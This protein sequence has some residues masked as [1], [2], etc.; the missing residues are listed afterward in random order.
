M[1]IPVTQ[2]FYEDDVKP[3]AAQQCI[4]WIPVIPDTQGLAMSYL[5]G[6][7]GLK[8][9]TTNGTKS[10]RGA[11]VMDGIPY[12]V[13]GNNLYRVNA[14]GASDDLGAIAGT[15][16][17]SFADNGK[18]LCV[19]VPNSTG[20]IYKSEDETLTE[21]TDSNY[22]ALGPSLQVVYKDGYF[23]HLAKDLYFISAL[24]DGLTY[25]ALD[26]GT[27]E[28]NPDSNTAIH[29]NRN[30]GY[31]AGSETIQQFQ[32]VG[33]ADF[34]FSIT[35]GAVIQKGVKAKFSVVDFD[36]SFV[37]LGGGANEQPAIWLFTGS[38]VVK[39]STKAIDSV[40]KKETEQ[41]LKDVY[42][43]THALDGGFFVCF[44]FSDTS[45]C[46]DADASAKTGRTIWH[47][48][49]SRTAAQTQTKWR[50][51]SIVQAYGKLLVGDILGPTIG[52]I[53]S[54]AFSEYGTLIDRDVATGPLHN[55]GKQ[56][57]VDELEVTVESGQG[58]ADSPEPMITMSYSTDGGNTFSNELA[59]SMGKV[60]ERNKRQIWRRLGRV[61]RYIMF[62]LSVSA[63]VKP[64]IIRLRAEL[65][66]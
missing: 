11:H 26:F 43:T 27:A 38:S 41:Q 58:N 23:T 45:F 16:R 5:K 1:D 12:F 53:D 40:I 62:R 3:I 7:P 32:N 8:A 42:A 13:N 47:E 17:V 14:D 49:Q 52:E 57:N 46:Y 55:N 20:Y 44:H 2:G 10:N 31:I 61:D 51:A 64:S 39:L 66:I 63:K 15:G 6:T 28:V 24:N 30:A 59:R 29:V 60:G 35:Q 50:V 19:V 21:I 33:G 4:N 54:N 25:G 18:Q 34:P 65:S 56:F 37:F 36:N 22:V 9:F 48:R